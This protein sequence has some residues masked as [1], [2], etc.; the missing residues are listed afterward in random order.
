MQFLAQEKLN[1]AR[2]RESDIVKAHRLYQQF[3]TSIA[4]DTTH[5][6]TATYLNINTMADSDIS[7]TST[8]EPRPNN[9]EQAEKF[10]EETNKVL[11]TFI[12]E[13]Q[14]F[15]RF[16]AEVACKYFIHKYLNELLKTDNAY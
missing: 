11:L 13:L 15:N 12:A 2:T 4:E 9:P 3:E 8:K 6:C 10:R 5:V 16:K 1:D 7:S 14:S